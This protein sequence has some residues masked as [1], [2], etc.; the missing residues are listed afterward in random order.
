M[1]IIAGAVSFTDDWSPRALA[2]KLAT[3]ACRYSFLKREIVID[4]PSMICYALAP[5]G[6]ASE[7][8][9]LT[10]DEGQTALIFDQPPNAR[11]NENFISK[12]RRGSLDWPAS[13]RRILAG[14]H[15]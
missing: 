1:P 5:D 14:A 11:G 8:L 7:H 10:S 15:I 12:I 13:S 3:D 4:C 2:D 9:K 6:Q